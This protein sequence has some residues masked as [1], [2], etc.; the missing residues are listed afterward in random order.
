MTWRATASWAIRHVNGRISFGVD[1]PH[2]SRTRIADALL[3]W[4]G[5][6]GW[7]P[8][9]IESIGLATWDEFDALTDRLRA[10]IRSG[11]M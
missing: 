4:S 9:P 5:S 7:K 3:E 11:R 6:A 10:D 8:L 2:R 1:R